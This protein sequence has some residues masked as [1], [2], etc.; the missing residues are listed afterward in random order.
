MRVPTIAATA[1]AA[2]AL[3]T[4]P[5]PVMA[6][7]SE[8]DL[9]GVTEALGDPQLQD[10]A[11]SMIGAMMEAVLDMPAAPLLD[12]AAR[13]RGEED[14]NLPADTRLG[15][16]AGEE[17]ADAAADLQRSVPQMMNAMAGMTEAF[18]AMLPAFRNMAEQA[19]RDLD[20][21]LL[22]PPR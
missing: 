8:P 7:T 15:D 9:S 12:A 10:R 20:E 14:A 13:L 2:A 3:A 11:A 22:P 18:A 6:Q 19:A 1:L 17:G 16:L 21:R 5:L 4:M